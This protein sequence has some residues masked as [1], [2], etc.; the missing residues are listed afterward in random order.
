MNDYFTLDGSD[1]PTLLCIKCEQEK[2]IT[3]YAQMKYSSGK[4]NAEYKQT[5]KSCGKKQEKIRAKLRRENPPPSRHEECPSCNETLHN[6]GR[7]GQ[8]VFKSW[9]LH[10]SHTTGKFLGYIC[11]TCNVGQGAFKDDPKR[12]RRAA[13][14]LESVSDG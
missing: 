11:H 10:H 3:D 6:L 13:D 1:L 7:F 9:R 8:T 12:L 14:W 4:T 2:P 5:C